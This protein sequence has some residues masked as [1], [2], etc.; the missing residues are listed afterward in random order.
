MLQSDLT[1]PGVSGD[2]AQHRYAAELRVSREQPESNI[3]KL[4]LAS[5]T[6]IR[7]FIFPQ[8]CL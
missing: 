7:K 3:T 8:V 4:V 6:D 5:E 1:W 2:W